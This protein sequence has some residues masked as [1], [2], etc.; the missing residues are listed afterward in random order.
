MNRNYGTLNSNKYKRSRR[1]RHTPIYISPGGL[2]LRPTHGLSL[3]WNLW[4][5]ARARG[6]PIRPANVFQRPKERKR[7]KEEFGDFF[8]LFLPV[9]FPSESPHPTTVTII[10]YTPSH[11]W[12]YSQKGYI[13]VL[14]DFKSDIFFSYTPQP[15]TYGFDAYPARLRQAHCFGH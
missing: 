8:F 14:S 4:T 15:H 13:Y 7:E 5:K 10:L 9:H 6:Y 11:H 12:S 2:F 1:G 3:R